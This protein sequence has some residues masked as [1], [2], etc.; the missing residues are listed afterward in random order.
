MLC[1]E[2]VGRGPV[3]GE[4]VERI[5]GR[6]ADR[7]GV[8]VL[9]GEAGIGKSRLLAGA[10][11]NAG[12]IAFTGRAV[13]VE[14]PVP[15]RPLTEAILAAMRGR[16]VPTDDTLAGFEGQLARLVPHWPAVAP[17]DESPLLLGESIARLFAVLDSERRSILVLEDLH[18]ADIETL[19]VVEYLCDALPDVGGWCVVT[20]RDAEATRPIVERL[21]RRRGSGVLRIGALE[22]DGV[23]HMVDACLATPVAPAGLVE[24]LH[25]HS[26]GNPF[27]IEELLAGLIAADVLAQVDGRWEILGTLTVDVPASLRDSVARRLGGLGTV[28]RRVI[29]AAGML[30]RS[31]TWELLP[32]VAEVDGR[33]TVE[34][35][36]AAVD[37]QLIEVDGEVDGFRFRHALTRE[38]V[39]AGLLPPQ[40]RDLAQRAL[41]AIERANP[42]L[43]GPNLELAAEPRPPPVNLRLQRNCSYAVPDAPGPRAHW[44][45][46]RRPLVGPACSPTPVHRRH[47]T[48]RNCSCT[49]SLRPANHRTRLRSANCSSSDWSRWRH[50]VN[51][52][53][54]CSWR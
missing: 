4:L 16:T 33:T 51:G 8:I 34:A 23:S 22:Q 38:A 9:A 49:S 20:T 13:P 54:H 52:E 24:F 46:Q 7:G 21:D 47:S 41:P 26:D 30:G 1:P 42:G 31:F 17:T 40:R 50:R 35:L 37:A 11:E 19:A 6:S 28:Q 45:P 53:R 32:G 39:V 25:R 3:L 29:G 14:S 18:W 5:A 2:M 15:Y 44:P 43:P 12:V 10:V 36:Q 27:L 48:P